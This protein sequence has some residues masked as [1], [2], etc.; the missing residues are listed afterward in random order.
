MGQANV[1]CRHC[2]APHHTAAI[3]LWKGFILYWSCFNPIRFY[4]LNLIQNHKRSFTTDNPEHTL[5]L[6]RT[7]GSSPDINRL[8]QRITHRVLSALPSQGDVLT[9]HV[10]GACEL[11]KRAIWTGSWATLSITDPVPPDSRSWAPSIHSCVTWSFR[12]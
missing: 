12:D 7:S 5:F 2:D 11:A 8:V 6:T 4:I 10:I 3:V 9:S 1:A